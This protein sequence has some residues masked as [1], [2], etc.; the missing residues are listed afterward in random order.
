MAKQEEAGARVEE[1]ETWKKARIVTSQ[2]TK[3]INPNL[4]HL[5][6]PGSSRVHR[7]ATNLLPCPCPKLCSDSVVQS[8]LHGH[9]GRSENRSGVV[10]LAGVERDRHYLFLAESTT[11]CLHVICRHLYPRPSQFFHHRQET[12]LFLLS[13]GDSALWI[14][15]G[16]SSDRRVFSSWTFH[17]KYNL[18]IGPLTL[19]LPSTRRAKEP[20]EILYLRKRSP[21]TFRT[22]TPRIPQKLSSAPNHCAK[23]VDAKSLF[24]E[25]VVRRAAQ[26]VERE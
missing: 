12:L 11:S 7:C 8:G 2:E 21:E 20:I 18:S 25:K 9:S 1:R 16:A 3:K 24:H 6:S 15:L 26:D 4:L 13:R 10:A 14:S 5:R 22:S 19:L 23:T 17:R